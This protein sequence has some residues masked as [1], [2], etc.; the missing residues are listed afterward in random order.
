[1]T[2][3]S[4]SSPARILAGSPGSSCCRPKISIDTKTSVGTI[5]ASAPDEEVE[6]RSPGHRE[7]PAS[8]A[9]GPPRRVTGHLQAGDAQQAVGNVAHAAQLRAVGPE[10]VAVVEVDDRPLLQDARGDLLV[11]LLALGRLAL[12]ARLL[13]QRVG[14]GVAVAGVVERLLA[15]VEAVEVAVGVGAAAPGEHVGLEVALV[16]HVERG[17]ELGRPGSSRRSRPRASSTG[18]RRPGAARRRWSS[19]PA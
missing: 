15:G 7:A 10:P 16:G 2:V 8:A 12:R 1:M 13:Q 19:S 9:A 17:R 4:C 6:H 18:R 14:L 5:V 11:D 3:G